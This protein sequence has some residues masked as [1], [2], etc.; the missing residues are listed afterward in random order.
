MK[1]RDVDDFFKEVD[2]RID[3]RLQVILTGGA[4]GVLF[5]MKRATFDIDFEV[6]LL[7]GKVK[8]NWDALQRALERA[9]QSTK[10]TP[11]Y[12]EDI[13]RWSSIALPVKKSQAYKRIGKIDVRI[14]EPSLWAIG[15][16]A[17]YLSSDIADLVHVLKSQTKN[18]EACARVWGKAIAVSPPSAAQSTFKRQVDHFF[19]R[20]A[21][22]IWGKKANPEKLKS[23]FL[24]TARR[25][26][27]VR[28]SGN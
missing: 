26:R 20:Y 14:L 9:S 16:L 10:I 25:S 27:L 15:K 17:R 12:A 3:F 24:K 6:H 1:I 18:G 13:D 28:S 2:R 19:D 4:A 23:I 8:G 21:K 5:G 22:T 7:K 11:Q